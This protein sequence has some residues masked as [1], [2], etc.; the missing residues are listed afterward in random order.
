MGLLKRKSVPGK[1]DMTLQE[2]K[3]KKDLA[4]MDRQAENHSANA[5]LTAAD[6]IIDNS[7]KPF[8]SGINDM[9]DTTYT[10]KET[11]ALRKRAAA[12]I[13]D[14]LHGHEIPILANVSYYARTVLVIERKKGFRSHA[15][16]VLC[17]DSIDFTYG[18]YIAAMYL[19]EQ[20]S[21]PICAELKR[22]ANT[23]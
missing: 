16:I 9:D 4:D 13:R 21:G 8:S 11:P 12:V 14:L 10:L 3:R 20:E 22:Q 15:D 17:Q 7:K 1:A 5:P 18:K 6:I 19:T 23:K 2:E